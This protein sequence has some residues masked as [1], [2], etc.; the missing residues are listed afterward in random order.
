MS[1]YSFLQNHI[2]AQNEPFS[3]TGLVP[4]IG[5]YF[6]PDNHLDLFYKHYVKSL[7]RDEILS[8]TEMHQD[9]S[10]VLID[11]DFRFN[12]SVGINRQ[13]TL[14]HIHCIVKMYFEQIQ[15][16]FVVPEKCYAYIFEK[17]CPVRFQ[18]NIKDG[19][20]IMFPSIISKPDIQYEIRENIIS[21]I[22]DTQCLSSIGFKNT[23]NDL[24]D[25]AVIHRN[26]WLMYGSC[27]NNQEAYKLTHVY[28]TEL[29]E[30]E[31]PPINIL[32]KLLSIRNCDSETELKCDLSYFINEAPKRYNTVLSNLSQDVKTAIEL[33]NI[34]SQHRA[35]NY[36]D[37]I[38]LGFCLH[39]IDSTELLKTWIEFSKISPKFEDGA[40][41]KYWSKFKDEGLTIASLYRWAKIDNPEKYK[42]IKHSEISQILQESL[43]GTNYDVAQVIYAMNKHLYVNAS[44][45]NNKWYGFKDHRWKEMDKGLDLRK[46]ISTELAMEYKKMCQYYKNLL[47]NCSDEEKKILEGKQKKCEEMIK[48]VKMTNFKEKVMTEC[49]ELFY[50]PHFL[51]KLDSNVN[52]LGFENGVFDLERLYFRD[53][54]PDDYISFSTNIDYV[55][56]DQESEYAIEINNFIQKVL[57][58]NNV[59]KY[60]LLLLSSFLSGKV[61]DQKFHIWTGSGGN[62]KSKLVELFEKSFGDY[63][64]KLPITVLTQKRSGSSAASPE[65]AK[66]KGKRFISLQEPEHNDQIHVGF[67][68][69]LSGGDVIQARGLF[70]D[71]VEFKPQFKIILTCNH[72]PT[73]PSTD[74]GTWRRLRVVDFPSKFVDNPVNPGEFKKENVDIKL[75]TWRSTFMSLLLELH[76]TYKVYG[77]CEPDV[78]T[79][80]TKEYQK[81]SDFFMEFVDEFII[82]TDDKKDIVQLTPIMNVFRD[83]YKEMYSDKP[84]GRKVIKPYL[85]K[86]F[87]TPMQTYGWKN[88]KLKIFNEQIP[89]KTEENADDNL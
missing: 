35:D 14:N 1:I 43:S 32:P 19:I 36:N 89:D 61:D 55:E 59:R 47:L 45:K 60:V 22:S 52:L 41:E 12:E 15:K 31:I 51:N 86:F 62:G 48:N 27:K 72:L 2:A 71:P 30:L 87:G 29:N 84:P 50:D 69:E 28:D 58:D 11:I 25:K 4:M 20:H 17:S 3:H 78:V 18:G 66:T 21:L 23:I 56:F 83:W 46:K 57:P 85:E 49:S 13:Y 73:I 33:V 63:C 34:L 8:I 10:P 74:G 88:A 67:M 53:G 81:N 76:K 64:G 77:L 65:I 16:Y 26:P 24:I 70:Q 39:N 37:W 54:L 38:E 79:Q 75:N 9:I 7:K 44:I 68:K 42:E 6:I 40:C 80:Y 82:K 5:K